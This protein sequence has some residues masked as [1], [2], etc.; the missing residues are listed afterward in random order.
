MLRQQ[1]TKRS[2]QQLLTEIALELRTGADQVPAEACPEV[3]EDSVAVRLLH[4]GVDVVARVAQLGDLLRQQLHTLGAV[5]E[6]D[7]LVYLQLKA[8]QM[9]WGQ[10]LVNTSV[11]EKAMWLRN[12]KEA[13]CK[14]KYS[15]SYNYVTL[16]VIQYNL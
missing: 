14:E 5:T 11:G 13:I 16:H 7:A 3:V 4:A 10:C 8:E 6:D 15:Y 2:D 12:E 9:V 1:T